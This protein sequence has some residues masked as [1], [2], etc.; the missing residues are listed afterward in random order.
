VLAS[1]DDEY[2]YIYRRFIRRADGTVLDAHR[3]GLR[4]FRLRVKKRT[5]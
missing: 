4:A 2:V 3:Y 1:N 5:R